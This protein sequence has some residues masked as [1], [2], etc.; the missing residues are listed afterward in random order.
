MR[1]VFYLLRLRPK[2]NQ[3]YEKK[4]EEIKMPF[5]IELE[6]DPVYTKGLEKGIEK[7]LEKGIEK[8]QMEEK[9]A[10]ARSLLEIHENETIAKIVRLPIEN[11]KKLR[12]EEENK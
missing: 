4:Q 6:S 7:G 10:I 12:K 9:I 11:I 8:G 1:K 5:V 2:L 3:E